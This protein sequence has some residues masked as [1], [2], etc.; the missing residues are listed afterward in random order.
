MIAH[1]DVSLSL[2][3]PHPFSCES[4]KDCVVE[5]CVEQ[6]CEYRL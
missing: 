2:D 4:A 3:I 1:T 6:W 5:F